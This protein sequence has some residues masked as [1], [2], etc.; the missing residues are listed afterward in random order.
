MIKSSTGCIKKNVS[1]VHK[2]YLEKLVENENKNE[3]FQKLLNYTT[4]D[5]YVH[6]QVDL[7]FKI[8]Y[9]K[10]SCEQFKLGP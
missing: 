7:K 5:L 8:C 9:M 3:F 4:S 2:I 10:I 1:E 6:V